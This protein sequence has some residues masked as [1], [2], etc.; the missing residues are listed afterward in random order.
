MTDTFD[1]LDAYSLDELCEAIDR[2]CFGM[3]MACIPR[4]QVGDGGDG[5]DVFHMIRWH[6]YKVL[7]L[8]GA[9]ELGRAKL[10]VDTQASAGQTSKPKDD[11]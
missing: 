11:A 5:V 8:I 10:I 2:R 3:F 7:E 9:V 4:K 6:D 1:P